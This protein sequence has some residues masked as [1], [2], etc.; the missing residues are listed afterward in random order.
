[1]RL[2]V[3]PSG[4]K[5]LVMTETTKRVALGTLVVIAIVAA[6]LALW[7][8]KLVIALVCLGFILAAATRP[9]FERDRAVDRVASVL[10][11]PKRKRLRDT[12]DLIDLELGALVRGQ[13]L[14][15]VLVGTVWSQ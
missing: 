1:L 4:E 10:P 3:S 7:K 6:A 15:V 13:A 9:G 11:R 12:W 8:L 5:S 14:L 2:P